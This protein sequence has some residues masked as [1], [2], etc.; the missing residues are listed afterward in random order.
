[1]HDRDKREA[2]LL[3]GFA[4]SPGLLCISACMR[5]MDL[6]RI[7]SAT[8]MGSIASRLYNIVWHISIAGGTTRRLD[9]RL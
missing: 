9:A 1:M 6:E 2:S 7:G 8:C 3:D 4:A 5:A